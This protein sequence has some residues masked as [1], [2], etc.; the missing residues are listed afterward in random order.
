MFQICIKG[1]KEVIHLKYLVQVMAL[2]SCE[3]TLLW[4]YALDI[5][6]YLKIKVSSQIKCKMQV[7]E[8][9]V[10]RGTALTKSAFPHNG[11]IT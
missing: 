9:A 8:L 10:I 1:L 3:S 7:Y 2:F 6:T 4:N 11:E 5:V